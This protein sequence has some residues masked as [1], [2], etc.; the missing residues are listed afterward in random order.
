MKKLIAALM[1]LMILFSFAAAETAEVQAMNFKEMLSEEE[2]ATGSYVDL[3]ERS[4]LPVSIW[5]P[6]GVFTDV[7]L[8]AE[9]TEKSPAFMMLVNENL[10]GSVI[11]LMTA[12]SDKDYAAVLET[13]NADKTVSD[14]T[15]AQINGIP[16]IAWV[17]V[18]NSDGKDEYTAYATYF[19]DDV[20]LI[21]F[22]PVLEDDTF[23]QYARL[24]SA[25]VSY[26]GQ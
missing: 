24:I 3:T 11:A 6:N 12:S 13:L 21:L 14:V 10:V 17:Q 15:E 5:V 4:G 9:Q 2:L 8:T 23:L 26:T 25:S 20:K 16:T 22:F 1:A 7:Q 18:K 19:I